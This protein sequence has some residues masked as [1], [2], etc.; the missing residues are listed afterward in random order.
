MG[1]LLLI[2][3][4]AGGA[5]VA[6]SDSEQ[7]TFHAP[8]TD[9]FERPGALTSELVAG[10]HADGSTGA[11]TYSSAGVSLNGTTQ[12][13]E[14]PSLEV[15]NH[16][17]LTVALR[18]TPDFAADADEPRYL[19]DTSA[20]NRYYLYHR[21]NVGS[22]TLL[23]VLNGSAI[24]FIPLA[25]Y[26]GFWNANQENTLI[27]T[28]DD[29]ANLTNVWLN[30]TAILTGDPS[31]FANGNPANLYLG[32]TS[33]PDMFFDGEIRDIRIAS[34]L[35]DASDRAL[36]DAGTRPQVANSHDEGVVLRMPLTSDTL[37]SATL[38]NDLSGSA[39]HITSVVGTPVFSADGVTLDGA[40][41]LERAEADWRG[42]D[43]SGSISAWINPATFPGASNAILVSSDTAS[44]TRFLELYVTN[45]GELK[46]AQR[47]GDTLSLVTATTTTITT[48]SWWH[49]V[50][51]SNGTA[52]ALFV[53][54]IPQSLSVVNANN[55]DWFADTLAR[56]NFTIGSFC[57]ASCPLI[58][59]DGF[60][61]RLLVHSSTLTPTEVTALYRAGPAGNPITT[62]TVYE[63]MIAHWPLHLPFQ[64]SST[65]VSELVAGRTGVLT[66]TPPTLSATE[67]VDLNGSSD[68]VLVA[69]D[70]AFSFG[71]GAVTDSPFSA[72]AW[73]NMDDATNFAIMSKDTNVTDCEWA[74]YFGGGDEVSLIL[75]DVNG[76][77]RVSQ[78]SV[79][80]A[81]ALQGS[82]HHLG[83]SYD[84]SGASTGVALYI[85]GA[86]VAVTDNA[87]TGTY[88]AMH[89]TVA[90]VTIGRRVWA[91]AAYAN[92]KLDAPAIWNRALS[93]PEF[94]AFAR[95]PRNN[96]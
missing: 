23:L 92:G 53:N 52:W 71:D 10:N 60:I 24:A 45:A 41:Y 25:T 65:V 56:D 88:N 43:N 32:S 86:A 85:D 22:N 46:V 38:S 31:T 1:R 4:L 49:V 9:G 55:G 68:Y 89:P 26:G 66:G 72:C 33:T 94:A 69:D 29:T 13:L 15:F 48:G 90:D 40:E 91:G 37:G 59:F 79:D 35:W 6:P 3:L 7:L 58:L 57:A 21:D 64:Q 8:L 39:D 63:G 81:T 70:D 11:P 82:W 18:F 78:F 96:P 2:A 83:F 93:A 16:L 80:T 75:C 19:F 14:F 5:Q 74:F 42:G 20:G 77:N 28:A 84:G 61:G 87:N 50:L 47:N 62:P 76:S 95:L 44:D 34:R 36:Y 67:G 73:V 17:K 27:I 30:G 12:N 54:G 51:T